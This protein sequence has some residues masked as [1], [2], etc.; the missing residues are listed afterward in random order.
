MAGRV[1]SAAGDV[2][3]REERRFLNRR[4]GDLRTL[5]G[6]ART[7]ITQKIRRILYFG[8]SLHF[9]RAAL[10]LYIIDGVVAGQAQA[11]WFDAGMMMV[12]LTVLLIFIGAYQHFLDESRWIK[13]IS[14]VAMAIS[15]S[16]IWQ[17]LEWLY[18]TGT[19]ENS[20]VLFYPLMLRLSS[21]SC[22]IWAHRLIVDR[23]G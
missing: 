23:D 3:S 15:C 5:R 1:D 7:Q 9:V 12:R 14:I 11:Y 17:D 10:V 13:S 22:L 18:L 19:T 8:L 2:L 6:E 16:L 21:L 20:L 4:S